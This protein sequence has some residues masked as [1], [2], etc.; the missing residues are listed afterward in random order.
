MFAAKLGK[1]VLALEPW[2]QNVI[3]IHKATKKEN[4]ENNIHLFRNV[5]FNKRKK[6]AHLEDRSNSTS[7][8]FMRYQVKFDDNNHG[9]PL[10][11]QTVLLD[12]LVDYLPKRSDGSKY[13]KA[14]MR[15]GLNGLERFAFQNATKLFQAIDIKAIYMKWSSFT[16]ETG[17]I[18]TD[19]PFIEQMLEFL[20]GQNMVPLETQTNGLLKLRQW[21][22]WPGAVVWKKKGF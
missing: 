6:W 11:I 2:Q 7:A 20:V 22:D 12:D 10:A 8:E 14:I 17:F 3:R 16:E 21:Q 4:L 18:K 19:G 13:Q 9:N 5:V 1:Q 15:A